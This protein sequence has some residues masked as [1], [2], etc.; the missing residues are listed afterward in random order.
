MAD[1]AEEMD[2]TEEETPEVPAQ[3]S[4]PD[5]TNIPV[6]KSALSPEALQNLT[7]PGPEASMPNDAQAS[8]EQPSASQHGASGS[9]DSAPQQN[10]PQT[11]PPQVSTKNPDVLSR[12]YD[13]QKQGLTDAMKAATGEANDKL[14]LLHDFAKAQGTADATHQIIK[15]NQQHQLQIQQDK[16][17]TVLNDIQTTKIDPG[18]VWKNAGIPGTM[19]GLAGLFLGTWGSSLART[20][21]AALDIFNKTVDNDLQAQR[22]DVENKRFAAQGQSNLYG[23]MRQEFGDS[24]V[25]YSAARLAAQEQFKTK[26]DA[27]AA[28]AAAG[29]PGQAGLIQASYEQNMGKLNEQIANGRLDLQ[30][31]MLNLGITQMHMAMPQATP[32]QQLVQANLD[33][34]LQARQGLKELRYDPTEVSS[35]IGGAMWRGMQTEKRR[36][37]DQ[38]TEQFAQAAQ[39]LST[40]MGRFNEDQKDA[41]KGLI[42]VGMGD[43]TTN[44][45]EKEAL[46]DQLIKDATM[47]AG[48]AAN[49]AGK[50]NPEPLLKSGAVVQRQNINGATYELGADGNYHRIV[51]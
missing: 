24:D 3:M 14:G 11:I 33:K 12:S 43:S 34:M 39:A 35:K 44:L 10:I 31:K 7:Q 38:F 25:A 28:Q 15:E 5:G 48:V 13:L 23:M 41:I 46:M 27:V 21:N 29:Q 40:K 4:A 20:P 26:I 50:Y 36:S 1:N 2:D 9:W 42:K 49:Y 16:Y 51:R 32:D 8:F 17:N 45:T 18:R 37:Y 19:L 22:T 6:V 47:R 30:Q